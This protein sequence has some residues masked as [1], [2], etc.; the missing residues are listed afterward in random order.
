M[1]KNESDKE[2]RMLQVGVGMER[3]QAKGGNCRGEN[4]GLQTSVSRAREAESGDRQGQG[5]FPDM[6]L[7]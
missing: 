4:I 6:W 5:K 3:T 2:Q 7:G 1:T